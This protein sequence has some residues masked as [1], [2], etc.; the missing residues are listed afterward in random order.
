M[1]TEGVFVMIDGVGENAYL[2][3]FVNRQ[4]G[5]QEEFK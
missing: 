3:D 2:F 1:G 5:H 4:L